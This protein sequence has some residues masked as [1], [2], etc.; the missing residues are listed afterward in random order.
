MD[1]VN[2]MACKL[3]GTL[4]SSGPLTDNRR[5]TECIANV[6]A[7]SLLVSLTFAIPRLFAHT[8]TD[9]QAPNYG[10]TEVNPQLK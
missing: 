4:I 5:Q 1:V 2:S 9:A 10:R 8:P 6:D 7:F 3:L